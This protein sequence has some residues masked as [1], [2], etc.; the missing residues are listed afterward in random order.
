MLMNRVDSAIIMHVNGVSM[1]KEYVLV[2]L[3]FAIKMIA[4]TIIWNRTS[5]RI[6]NG[7]TYSHM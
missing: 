3:V 4:E 2:I 7:H 6:T 1:A 5:T